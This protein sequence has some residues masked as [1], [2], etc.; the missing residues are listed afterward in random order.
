ME[1]SSRL[2]PNRQTIFN[3]R[4]WYAKRRERLNKFARHSMLPFSRLCVLP[5]G[6]SKLHITEAL[7]ENTLSSSEYGIFT[8]NQQTSRSN[9]TVTWRGFPP[10]QHLLQNGIRIMKC[11]HRCEPSNAPGICS[12]IN[13]AK[14]PPP[15]ARLGNQKPS[16]QLVCPHIHQP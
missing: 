11:L 6:Y 15:K 14:K 5:Q 1:K 10:M 13:I 16:H 2:Y 9:F 4:I 12:P 7:K 8:F 3:H